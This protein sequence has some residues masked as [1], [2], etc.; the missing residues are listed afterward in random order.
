MEIVMV[1][2]EAMGLLVVGDQNAK[3]GLEPEEWASTWGVRNYPEAIYFFVEV[4]V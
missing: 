2:T 3:G 4:V 1:Y